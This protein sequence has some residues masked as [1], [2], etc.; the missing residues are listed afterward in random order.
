MSSV[1]AIG[2]VTV[3]IMTV[4][5]G[6]TL[7][8]G[9]RRE[10]RRLRAFLRLVAFIR[11][12]IGGFHTPLEEIYRRFDDK[13]PEIAPFLAS[14]RENGFEEAVNRLLPSLD[15]GDRTG[16]I[17]REFAMGLG[18]SDAAD[19]VKRCELC[20][21]GLAE[22]LKRAEDALPGKLKVCRA[23]SVSIAV[24]TVILLI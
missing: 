5:L 4:L 2:M 10:S 22:E 12:Q 18:K 7:A 23:L 20:E 1:K 17:L 11:T 13:D 16:S 6:L 19:Q 14:M 3:F 9:Y 8:D 24:M 15:L 21:A